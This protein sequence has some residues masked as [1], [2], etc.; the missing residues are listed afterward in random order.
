M[1]PILVQAWFDQV[2]DGAKESA[3]VLGKAMGTKITWDYQAP[4]QAD[5]EQQN[6][7]LERAIASKP[8][9]IAIDSNDAQ[10]ALPIIKEAQNRGIPIVLYTCDAPKGSQIPYVSDNWYEMGI[11]EGQELLKKM[12]GKGNVA[13][14]G[15][16]PTNSPHADRFRA[17]NDLFKAT[18]GVK[19]VATALD[20]DD[21]EKAHTEASRI[22]AANPDLNG[23]AV[24]D[25]AGPVGVALAIKEAGKVGKVKIVGLDSVPQ[26]QELMRTGVLDLSVST[27]PRTYGQLVTL[28]LMMQNLGVA[29]P[30]WYQVGTG[31]LTPDMVKNGDYQF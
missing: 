12:G 3:E 5:L 25:A 22:L 2:H 15:G 14:M 10:A 21:V 19:I 1:I 11:T 7:L 24:A 29:Q 6:Q 30:Q 26:L 23:F 8:D 27:K 16:V 31:Y 28:S 17:L 18:Q 4:A 9:G 20:Y 13:I